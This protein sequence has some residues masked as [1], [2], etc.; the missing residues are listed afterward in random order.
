MKETDTTITE[1]ES[2]HAIASVG[3]ERAHYIDLVRGICALSIVF[4]HT[5]FHSGGSY[6]PMPMRSISLL[7]DV[8]AFFFIAGMTRAYIQKDTIL[9]QLFK[10]SMIFVLLGLLCNLID[11]EVTWASIFRP[12]FLMGI[13]VSPLFKSV[14]GSYWFVPVY[15]CTIILGGIIIKYTGG[16]Y[17]AAI[18]S[19]IIFAYVLAFGGLLDFAGLNFLGCSLQ[20]LLFP[21][22]SY[23]FGYWCQQYI[24]P[25]DI[26]KRREFAFLLAFVAF[27]VFRLCYLFEGSSVYNLQINKFPVKLPYIAA[28]CL[29]MS[30]IIFFDNNSLRNR[31]FEHIGRNAIFYYAGQGVS[32]SCIFFISPYI[33]LE[34]GIK[35]PIMFAINLALAIIFSEALRLLDTVIIAVIRADKKALFHRLLLR[36]RLLKAEEQDGKKL[37]TS[38]N[39]QHSPMN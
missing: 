30:A 1:G 16:G 31:F 21:V 17:I 14:S 20:K 15:A 34:W 13:N 36:C 39:S 10:L 24:I 19:L 38:S 33:H 12:M 26:H 5:C 28:S 2:N 37:M 8:P 9:S 32:S 11:G 3:R 4:I 25:A 18:V 6:V 7:L 29:S 27:I 35:L 22:A 23:L